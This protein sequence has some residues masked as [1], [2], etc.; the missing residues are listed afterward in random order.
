VPFRDVPKNRDII[1][2]VE[3]IRKN[4]NLQPA[5]NN[6]SSSSN[7]PS[8]SNNNYN[9]QAAS[10]SNT[11]THQHNTSD[12]WDERKY[13]QSLFNDIDHNLDGKINFNELHEALKRG[14]PNSEFDPITV[15][16][17]L[18]KYDNDHDNE[19]NFEEFYH[20]FV[21]VTEQFNEF[22]DI[23]RDS[24]GFIDSIELNEAMR[25]RGFSCSPNLYS[26]LC[27]EI[28]RMYNKQRGISFDLYVRIIARFDYL[29]QR[30]ALL[31]PVT[32]SS[33]FGNN[34]EIFVS[35]NFFSQ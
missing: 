21:G 13:F 33:H 5:T 7:Q 14:Q 34:F 4:A 18:S 26:Y 30:F 6:S 24:S 22:L 8:F 2:F 32:K 11:S 35:K 15:G 16:F 19:I 28:T 29:K 23:D 10:N 3:Y 9:S 1:Q 31:D 17:L 25:R 27:H 12:N 20:L